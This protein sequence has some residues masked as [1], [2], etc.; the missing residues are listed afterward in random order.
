MPVLPGLEVPYSGM[1]AS[2]A[3]GVNIA[4]QASPSSDSN[5]GGHS[6]RERQFEQYT[7]ASSS[8]DYPDAAPQCQQSQSPY[9]H[10]MPPILCSH[11][12]SSG[13]GYISNHTSDR[14]RNSSGNSYP[15]SD[16][17]LSHESV[18]LAE[19]GNLKK[20]SPDDSRMECAHEFSTA[21][22]GQNECQPHEQGISNIS[23]SSGENCSQEYDVHRQSA[24]KIHQNRG[25][26]SNVSPA[27]TIFGS[28]YSSGNMTPYASAYSSS[29]GQNDDNLNRKVT[30]NESV[31]S[32]Q[33][34]C[35]NTI[36]E[37]NEARA[38]ATSSLRH[39]TLGQQSIALLSSPPNDPLLEEFARE[40]LPHFGKQDDNHR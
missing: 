19:F 36:S 2:T 7:A 37:P 16:R 21:S 13:I 31:A 23:H 39:D 11:P 33:H 24:I 18:R 15:F 38:L 32:K 3:A 35:G 9:S 25:N 14:K 8:K 30:S 4:A 17:Q 10:P 34:T 27:V 1:F 12:A 20:G 6:A 29:S 26:E 40:Y 5:I 22:V 28:S